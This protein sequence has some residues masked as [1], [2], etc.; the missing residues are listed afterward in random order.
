MFEQDGVEVFL[1]FLPQRRGD[2]E[3]ALTASIATKDAKSARKAF[4]VFNL[5]FFATFAAEN[6]FCSASPRLC[7][8]KS[9]T[10]N[11]QIILLTLS[12]GGPV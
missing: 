8:D 6:Y 5:R 10:E 12:A 2:A 4:M 11:P 9:I 1:G 7:G 3:K